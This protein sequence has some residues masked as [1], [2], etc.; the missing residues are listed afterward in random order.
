MI[1]YFAADLLWA[2][3]IKKTGE[4]CGVPCRP[5]RST[6]MLDAR[7]ADSP[8]RGLVVDLD[9]PESAL[10]LIRAL[11][12][13]PSAANIRI[14]AFGPHIATEALDQARLAGANVVL[15]RGAFD[16]RLQDCLSEL[17]SPLPG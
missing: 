10:E 11:R 1:L 17:N 12:S 16:R 7:L 13:R 8:V 4:A 14:L 15:A 9:A 2:T 3:K 5:V 6:E